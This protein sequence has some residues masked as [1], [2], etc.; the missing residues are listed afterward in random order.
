MRRNT[1]VPSGADRNKVQN[2]A[3]LGVNHDL[4]AKRIGITGEELVVHFEGEL[5]TALP[6]MKAKVGANLF[7]QARAGNI[8]AIIFWLKTRA[9]WSETVHKVISVSESQTTQS[10]FPMPNAIIPCNRHNACPRGVPQRQL[11]VLERMAES[12]LKKL[13]CQANLR[14]L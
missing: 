1:Y 4:I 13:Q 14:N 10:R 3:A 2:L 6:K 9:G 5:R 8:K 11:A 12:A 7:A